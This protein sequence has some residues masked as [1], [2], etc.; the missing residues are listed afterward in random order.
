MSN[1]TDLFIHC[2]CC[3]KEIY[4]TVV[5]TGDNLIDAPIDKKIDLEGENI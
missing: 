2:P 4:M 3:G 1:V 5:L